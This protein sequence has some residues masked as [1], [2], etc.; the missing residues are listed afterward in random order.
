MHTREFDEAASSISDV[1]PVSEDDQALSI[2]PRRSRAKAS[3]ELAD[4]FVG[5]EGTI[6]QDF[7]AKD[8][9][10]E[11][12]V[13]KG[14]TV[15]ILSCNDVDWW[16]VSCEGNLGYVPRKFVSVHR[17]GEEHADGASATYTV[18]STCVV[19]TG[20][21]TASESVGK[22]EPGAHIIALETRMSDQNIMRVRCSQGWLS[23]TS[24]NG[25]ALLSRA[26]DGKLDAARGQRLGTT[27]FVFWLWCLVFA[28][29]SFLIALVSASF[30]AL[31]F[32]IENIAYNVVIF[33]M[34][35]AVAANSALGIASL[36]NGHGWKSMLA[37]GV[38]LLLLNSM[39]L[40]IAVEVGTDNVLPSRTNS[41]TAI[42]DHMRDMMRDRLACAQVGAANA[43]SGSNMNA[44]QCICADA[45]QERMYTRATFC[46]CDDAQGTTCVQNYLKDKKP[47]LAGMVISACVYCPLLVSYY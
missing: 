41:T 2:T 20:F 36:M 26:G 9:K 21:R 37:F 18:M 32:E 40:W 6:L 23:V 12:S 39:E 14:T 11:L 8:S 17:G 45:S 22:L 31:M 5:K 4:K 47:L 13:G 38:S 42:H 10:K 34:L 46:A 29:T 30:F 33:W 1:L 7:E 43:S 16:Y 44:T 3:A 28:V 35:V 19:R 24:A 15:T 25:K 27:W